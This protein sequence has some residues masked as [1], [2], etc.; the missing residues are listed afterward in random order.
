MAANYVKLGIDSFLHRTLN[1]AI[2]SAF[3]E[4]KYDQ[5]NHN[6]IIL[7]L[8]FILCRMRRGGKYGATAISL[9]NNHTA[10]Y[11]LTDVSQCDVGMAP[12]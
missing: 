12:E 1:F 2:H 4:F 8:L 9:K 11:F 6:Y 10:D 3:T 7:I 5:N